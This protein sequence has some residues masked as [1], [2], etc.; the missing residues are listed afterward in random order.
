MPY[1]KSSRRRGQRGLQLSHHQ[2]FGKSQ[3]GVAAAGIFL[4]WFPFF[5]AAEKTEKSGICAKIVQK[6]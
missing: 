6:F 3:G 1:A 4:W 5:C 2:L